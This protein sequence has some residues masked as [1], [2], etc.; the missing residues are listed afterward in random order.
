MRAFVMSNYF[1][2][3]KDVY[4][5]TREYNVP[6]KE[7]LV[8]FNFYGDAPALRNEFKVWLTSGVLGGSSVEDAPDWFHAGADKK[9]LPKLLREAYEQVTSDSLL[10]MCLNGNGSVSVQ[11]LQVADAGYQLLSDEAVEIIGR[12]DRVRMV[13]C[14]GQH[15]TD[16]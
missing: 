1:D 13:A 4:K 9:A 15:T 6:K 14:L 8:E 2:I 11:I 5:K 7:L 10:A 16:K 12:E 3:A